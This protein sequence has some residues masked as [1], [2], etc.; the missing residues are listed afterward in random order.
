M[1]KILLFV[2]WVLIAHSIIVLLGT[3]FPSSSGSFRFYLGISLFGWCVS[4]VGALLIEE[5]I[6]TTEPSIKDQL[7]S[8]ERL[9]S[10]YQ[11]VTFGLLFPFFSF[12]LGQK[13]KEHGSLTDDMFWI[14]IILT[15]QAIMLKGSIREIQN[16]PVLVQKHKIE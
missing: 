8:F 2:L 16:T 13:I 9:G 5:S 10:M 4:E 1:S 15:L 11:I 12:H 3:C 14:F 7:E 6:R